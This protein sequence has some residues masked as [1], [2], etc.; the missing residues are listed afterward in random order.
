MFYEHEGQIGFLFSDV[1]LSKKQ[2]VYSFMEHFIRFVLAIAILIGSRQYRTAL[3]VFVVIEFVEIIDYIL[4]Y[5]E[6]WFD[7]KVFT[8]NTI[9]VGCF[10]LTILYEKYAK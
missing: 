3:W 1:V 7:S 9:K 6:P 5:G 10:G 4:T 8:W 2:W